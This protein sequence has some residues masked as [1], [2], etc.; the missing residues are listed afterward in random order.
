MWIESEGALAEIEK[1]YG[2]WIKAP[3]FNGKI[4]SVV[5]IP[6]FYTK[7]VAKS[8]GERSPGPTHH[9]PTIAKSN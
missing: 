9:S 8:I 6:G 4:R 1:Q 2:S 5:S 3:P 7:K